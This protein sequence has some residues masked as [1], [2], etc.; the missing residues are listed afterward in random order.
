M[1]ELTIFKNGA[2]LPTHFE[3]S[4]FDS[5][6]DLASGGSNFPPMIKIKNGVFVLVKNGETT[7]IGAVFT[8]VIV[9]AAPSK[10][11]A[12]KYYKDKYTG[13]EESNAA[14]DC[15][16]ANGVTPDSTI[17]HPV[18]ATCA[19]CPN[20]V[21]GSKVNELGNPTKLC[22]DYKRIVFYIANSNPGA[23]KFFRMDL[24]TMSMKTATQYANLLDL[25]GIPVHGVITR[26]A[27]DQNESYPKVIFDAIE[28]LSTEK[29][30]VIKQEM[31][32]PEI[33][34]IL[35][36]E[37]V[38]FED[39]QVTEQEETQQPTTPRKPKIILKKTIKATPEAET[40]SLEIKPDKENKIV[41]SLD[42]DLDGML[43]AME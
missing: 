13:K 37:A 27:F 25:K 17:K 22:T 19:L 20:N 29:Y 10:M 9:G 32:D 40:V 15:A 7:P 6:K 5:N 12:K 24:P 31:A 21:F 33:Q 3:K 18:C 35:T 8:G 11:P 16:S 4:D 30:A 36:M 38:V 23:D 1:N 39:A 41:R 42:A 2:Q 14:P 26:V 34:R 28:I 43:K